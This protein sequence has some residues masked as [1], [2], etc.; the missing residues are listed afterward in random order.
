MMRFF[1]KHLIHNYN[2]IHDGDVRAKYGNLTSS[3]GILANVILFLSKFFIGT[4]VNSVSITAD[5]VNN[6]SD[7][8]SSLISWISFKLSNRPA[9]EEHPFGHAR[10]EYIASMIVGILIL[11]LGIELVRNSWNKIIHPDAIAFSLLSAGILIASIL[12]KFWMFAY[13]RHYGKL[14]NSSV[15]MAT[16][17]DSLSDCMATGAVLASACISP[18]IHFN[19]D[20]YM[21]VVV[22]AFIMIAGGK[23]VKETLNS[24]LGASPSREE[25]AEIVNLIKS[26]EG[27]LGIHDLMIHDYG[28]N[29]RFASVHVEVSAKENIFVSHDMID[30]IER[31]IHEKLQIQMVIHMDP[32]DVDDEETNTMRDTVRNIVSAIDPLL[33]IHD[34]RMVKGN[35]H[36]N[37]I[38]DC[39][40]PY[41]I[42]LSTAQIMK[43]INEQ[44]LTLDQTYYAVVTFDH[45][46]TSEIK[47]NEDVDADK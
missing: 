32:I 12:M 13:N 30:N 28:P 31:E 25:V 10:Y 15:M 4:I 47:N 38:F 7:A 21:G 39:L 18:L 33:S 22:A 9:D 27:V 20:G 45:A 46:F 29:N 16:A 42:K 26:H 40:V 1:V 37:L 35:T 5:A 14:L 19:L 11:F 2:D 24:L 17:A 3:V 44:L 23:I 36:T 34:F 6:L 8:G 43:Q 41:Q